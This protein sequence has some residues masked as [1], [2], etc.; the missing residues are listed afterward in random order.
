MKFAKYQKYIKYAEMVRESEGID[1]TFDWHYGGAGYFSPSEQ[2]IRIGL[3]DLKN[4]YRVEWSRGEA[5]YDAHVKTAEDRM[6]WIILHELTHAKLQ[7]MEYTDAHNKTFYQVLER[8]AKQY[9]YV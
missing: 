3:G 7:A 9:L 2:R 8:M 1:C 4:T 6:R 5:L